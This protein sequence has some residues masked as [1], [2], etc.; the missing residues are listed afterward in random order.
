MSKATKKNRIAELLL[1]DELSLEDA[2]ELCN[3]S[4]RSIER[5][6]REEV[7]IPDA[8]KRRLADRFEV[9]VEFLMGW[10]R[11]PAKGAA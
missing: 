1:R 9:S 6:A 7:E 5:W 3:V 4:T 2:A 8:Q 11:I 10:D